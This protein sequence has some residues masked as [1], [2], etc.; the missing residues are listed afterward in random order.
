[1]CQI[2]IISKSLKCN[3]T[4]GKVASAS[5]AAS[6]LA[7]S[8]INIALMDEGAYCLTLAVCLIDL[9]MHISSN[10]N[11]FERRWLVFALFHEGALKH[12]ENL[13]IAAGNTDTS[14]RDRSATP[15]ICPQQKKDDHFLSLIY[16][17]GLQIQSPRSHRRNRGVSRV[18][19]R[20]APSRAG[21]IGVQFRGTDW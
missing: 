16:V 13:L 21:S 7:L 8:N 2:T 15:S 17:T 20:S 4:K 19:G 14:D 5:L 10:W 9:G 1:M 11:V 12:A 18:K 6:T 3:C